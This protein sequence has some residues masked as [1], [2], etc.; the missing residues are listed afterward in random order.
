MNP[1]LIVAGVIAAAVVAVAFVAIAFASENTNPCTDTVGD[2]T[3]NPKSSLKITLEFDDPVV[4]DGMEYY[5]KVGGYVEIICNGGDPDLGEYGIVVTSITS[6][7]GINTALQSGTLTKAGTITV[8]Y[9]WWDGTNEDEFSFTII[10]VEQHSHTIAYAGNGNTGGSMVKTAVSAS[11]SGSANITLATNGFTK[12]G[13]TFVGWKIGNTVY[14]PGDTISVAADATVTATAQWSANTLTVSASDIAGTSGIS[15]SNKITA[16][17]SNGA[18]LTYAVKSCTGGTATVNGSGAV[19]YKCPTV[20]SEVTYAV[21]VTVTATYSDGSTVS[22]DV[23]FSVLVDPI[24]E[25]TNSVTSGSLS[26]K[27]TG[28]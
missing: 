11:G 13:Y 9:K 10:A 2:Y 27:G 16:T 20:T 6:G 1:K 22:K 7:Y 4:E 17:A 25:F 3:G 26:V 5:V 14:Q 19:T 12:T 18:S 28:A 24:L 8:K 15:V 21:T 23:T